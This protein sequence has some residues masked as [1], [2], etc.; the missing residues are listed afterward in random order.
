MATRIEKWRANDGSEWA[1]QAKAEDRDALLAQVAEAMSAL[2]PVP[3][4]CNFA[5][6][7]GFVQ[8]A[9]A[10]VQQTK[11]ALYEL[12]KPHIADW[13]QGQAKEHGTTEDALIYNTHPSWFCRML[14]GCD[15][16]ERAYGRLCH[17][18]KDGREWGQS[19]YAMHPTEGEQIAL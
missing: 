4:E 6:G 17:I 9:T 12:A 11:E 3:N 8:Q 18:D 16:L 14:D 1:S 5:N 19:Y 7:G 2:R 13:I 15:P 10:A